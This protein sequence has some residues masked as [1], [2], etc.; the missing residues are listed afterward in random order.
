MRIGLDGLPLNQQ[1][2]GV[3]HYTLELAR[4][5]ALSAPGDHFEVVSPR[6]YLFD[7]K[8][9]VRSDAWPPNL[10]FVQEPTN[11]LTRR[12]W[13][14]G[15]PRYLAG[16]PV[17]LFHG[18]NFE[19]PLWTRQRCPTVLT[20]HDLSLL[21]HAETHEAR[22]VRRSRWRLPKMIRAA[23]MIITPSES[24][25]TEL[26]EQLRIAEEKVAAVPEAPRAVFQ[27]MPSQEAA[28][29]A[30]R[31]GIDKEFLLFVG[32][33]EPRKDLATLLR[34]FAEVAGNRESLRLVIAG[35]LGWVFDDL[36]QQIR[37]SGFADRIKLTGYLDD[38]ELR[39]LYSSCRA[40][41][42]PSIYEGFGLPPLEAM[43]CGA[44]VIAAGI[45]SLVEVCGEAAL[46]FDQRSADSLAR[47]MMEMLDN[48]NVSTGLI[49]AGR[50]R[51]AEYSWKRTAQ[52]TRAVYREAIDRFT[53]DLKQ[54]KKA[55]LSG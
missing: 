53:S 34:A 48:E 16:S 46:F 52:L 20:V 31:L 4:A 17:D 13:R 42:Y 55:S 49:K 36:L 39:A 22:H 5:M 6:P 23:T 33:I 40:F 18:T 30:R 10:T 11:I 54:S 14:V 35:R 9:V 43:A 21:L 41:I 2:T 7:R 1:L 25:R 3:G 27:P 12:W 26:R 32:T 44:P 15:L 51:A 47:A 50:E 8:F 45:A 37:D 24:V 38:E 29:I 19:V 28:A